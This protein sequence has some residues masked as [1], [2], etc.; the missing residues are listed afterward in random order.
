MILNGLVFDTIL[1]QDKSKEAADL[2]MAQLAF[3]DVMMGVII[4]WTSV[5]TLFNF[6][7]CIN[8]SIILQTLF[9]YNV[10][11]ILK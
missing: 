2:L 7:V 6:Q 11:M 10:I 1:R 9:I 5:Y 4:L 3:T 8:G